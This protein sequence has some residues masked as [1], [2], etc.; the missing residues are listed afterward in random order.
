MNGIDFMMLCSRF[1]RDRLPYPLAV[2]VDVDTEDR[3]QLL[4]REASARIDALMDDD[5]GAAVRTLVDPVVRIE[6]RGD[7][8]DPRRGTIR[9]HAAVRHDVAAVLTQQPGPDASSGGAVT[10]ALTSPA[11]APA[12]VLGSIPANAAGRRPTMRLE[13]ATATATSG[14]R[15]L[16]TATRGATAHEQFRTF[17]HRP[18]SAVGE[19][20]VARGRTYDNRRDTDAVAFFWMDFERDGRYIVYSEDTIDILPADTA[21]L[22][23][24][25][26]HHMA[27]A[28]RR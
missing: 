16:S 19:V 13:R 23:S 3:Y 21:G 24:E 17:F 11:Q 15:H 14:G 18:R 1:G 8:R 28:L 12:R 2:T 27:V 9:A 7:T 26:G 22:A 5:L 20:I 4:R 10:I 25:I 6:C